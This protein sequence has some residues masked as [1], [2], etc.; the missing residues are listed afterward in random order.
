[1]TRPETAVAHGCASDRSPHDLW[2]A[3]PANGGDGAAPAVDLTDVTVRVVPG[4]TLLRNVTWQVRPGEHWVVIGSNGAGKTTLMTVVGGQRHPT[5]GVARILGARM[6]HVDLRALREH[7]GFVSSAQRLLD[8]ENADARTVVLTGYTGTVQPLG[9]RYDARVRERA[10][11]LLARLGCAGLAE[12]PVRVCSQGERARIRIARAL[13][14]SPR[15][16][17]LDEPF[18]GLDLPAREDLIEALGRLAATEPGL[19]TVTVTHHLEEVPTGTTHALLLRD[20]RVIC[21]GTVD[22]VLTGGALSR[23]F[24]RPLVVGREGGRWYVRGVPGRADTATVG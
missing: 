8:A 12:R 16:L 11:R 10:D 9:E 22:E 14:G 5:T 13:M 3:A 24:D 17:L 18:A 20:G 7:I 15:L 4:R 6:G 23:C 1:M 21:S 2:D 19:A